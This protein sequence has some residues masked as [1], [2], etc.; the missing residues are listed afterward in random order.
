MPGNGVYQYA[1]QTGAEV[2]TGTV[3]ID[4]TLPPGSPLYAAG[5]LGGAPEPE[6]YRILRSDDDGLNWTVVSSQTL[7]TVTRLV[8]QRGMPYL[9]AIGGGNVWRSGDGGAT[10]TQVLA[11]GMWLDIALHPT[12]RD[13]VFAASKGGA[14]HVGTGLYRSLDHGQSW[15]QVWDGSGPTWPYE[16]HRVALSVVDPN[17]GFLVFVG[18]DN[19]YASNGRPVIAR[20]I[21]GGGAGSFQIV[22]NGPGVTGNYCSVTAFLPDHATSTVVYAA[23]TA[24][25]PAWNHQGVLLSDTGGLTWTYVLTHTNATLLAQDAA[26]HQVVY[27]AYAPPSGCLGPDVWRTEDGGST[28]ITVTAGLSDHFVVRALVASPTEAD[29]L[30][31]GGWACGNDPSRLYRSAN[32]GETWEDRSAGLPEYNITALLMP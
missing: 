22:W 26:D 12:N 21:S 5:V 18:G 27:K 29:V 16:A 24:W 3:T 31:V 4:T 28:W 13:V 10:W 32:R 9:Y 2:V 1:V 19:N 20:S 17:L 15:V 25:D 30:F 7:G 14:W 23:T 8:G 11:G 6:R